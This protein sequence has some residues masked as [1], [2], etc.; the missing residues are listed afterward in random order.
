MSG[1]QDELRV[2]H[3]PE[4]SRFEIHV[5]DALAGLTEYRDEPGR[6]VFTHTEIDP[7]FSGRGLGTRLIGFALGETRREGLR[8]VPVCSFVAA[9]VERHPE[10]RD[11]VAPTS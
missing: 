7:L 11:L 5:G 1:P 10:Y 8:V 9:F 2:V 4:Q 6:R 3:R